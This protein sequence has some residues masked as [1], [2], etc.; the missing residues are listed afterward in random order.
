MKFSDVIADEARLLLT[1][2]D[3]VELHS[4]DDARKYIYNIT[5][6]IYDYKMIGKIHDFYSESA[7]YHKQDK[8]VFA[9]LE[10]V[11][12]NVGEFCAAFPNLT[13]SIESIIIFKE[14]DDFYKAS[15]RLR[16]RGNNYGKSR[17]GPPTGKSLANNCLGMSMLYLKKLDGQW[18]ITFE[19]NN[20]SETWLQEVQTAQLP[21]S[22][23]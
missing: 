9:S 17:F 8:T 14:N 20:D 21:V 23:T 2:V 13:T 1:E 19:I 10:D 3:N 11:V 6:I 22:C 18:K 7:E 16:Y 4:N 12:H 5:K 15:R